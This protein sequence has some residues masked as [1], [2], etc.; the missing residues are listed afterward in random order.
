MGFGYFVKL[1]VIEWIDDYVIEFFLV[2]LIVVCMC[3]RY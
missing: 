2:G 3:N 1:N